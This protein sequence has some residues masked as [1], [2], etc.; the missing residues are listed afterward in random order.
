MRLWRYE[1]GKHC[2]NCFLNCELHCRES[3]T[4]DELDRLRRPKSKQIHVETGWN[5]MYRM[6]RDRA[7]A[8]LSWND[9]NPLLYISLR[10]V[11]WVNFFQLLIYSFSVDLP[12][13]EMSQ[14]TQ[15]ELLQRN[16]QNLSQQRKSTT[17]TTLMWK[18][19]FTTYSQCQIQTQFTELK[20]SN[21]Q[22]ILVQMYDPT[23]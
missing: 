3:E 23:D 22:H 6:R 5:T 10:A 4:F 17:T 1:E 13:S 2:K 9:N 12:I 15:S 7:T 19:D 8:E 18:H 16:V 11:W 21:N 14:T 20:F